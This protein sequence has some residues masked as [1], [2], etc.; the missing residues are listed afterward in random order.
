MKN[1]YKFLKG[2]VVLVCL[3]LPT[4]MSSQEKSVVNKLDSLYAR[5]TEQYDNRQL[6]EAVLSYIKI[7]EAIN[8]NPP[9]SSSIYLC[10]LYQFIGGIYYDLEDY[11]KALDFLNLALEKCDTL[12]ATNRADYPLILLDIALAHVGLESYEDA[13]DYMHLAIISDTGLL[14]ND[15]VNESLNFLIQKYVERG[16]SFAEA[17]DYEDALISITKASDVVY[18]LNMKDASIDLYRLQG[19]LYSTQKEYQ[20]AIDYYSKAHSLCEPNSA[21]HASILQ[22]IGD[23][24]ENLNNFTKALE[25]YEQ[26]LGV[27]RLVYGEEHVTY[28]QCLGVIGYLYARLGDYE[29]ALEC[30]FS[31]RS[32][33]E[34]VLGVNHSTYANCLDDIGNVYLR[35]GEIDAA[36]KSFLNALEIYNSIPEKES[37][38]YAKTLISIG[39]AY[40]IKGDYSKSIE[41]LLAA[42]EVKEK[43]NN[44]NDF[45]YDY[46][47][48][49]NN[50]GTSYALL[51]DYE[52]G[53]AFSLNSLEYCERLIGTNHPEYATLLIIISSYYLVLGEYGKALEYQLNAM[54]IQ[55]FVLGKEHPDYADTLDSIGMTYAYLNDDDKALDFFFK[56]LRIKEKTVGKTN[57]QYTTILHHIGNSYNSKHDYNN[58]LYYFNLAKEI[59]AN[60]LGVNHPRYV[61]NIAA[62]G[63]VYGNMGNNEKAKE[64]CFAALEARKNLLG[65]E[66]IDTAYA[67]ENIGSLYRNLVDYDSAIKC[68]LTA[69]SIYEKNFGKIHPDY[70]DCLIRIAKCYYSLGD[71]T[72]AADYFISFFD[73]ASSFV[74]HSFASLTETQRYHFWEQYNNPFTNELF[75]YATNIA[76]PE[77]SKMAYNA[78]LLGKGL[79]LNAE[80]EMRKLILESGDE[81]AIGVYNDIQANRFKLDKLYDQHSV[82][83][84]EIDSLS[85][86]IENLQRELIAR[87]KVYGDY[88]KNL[89]LEWEDVQESLGRHDI[90]I[91]F[92]TYTEK[93]TTFYIAITVRSDYSEPHIVK[94]FSSNDLIKIK[95]L[96]YYKTSI[97]NELIWG[98]LSNELNGIKNVFF[99][100]SGELCNISIENLLEE[101]GKHL[102]SDNRNYYR[103]TSTREVYNNRDPS[104]NLKHATIYGGIVYESPFY[105][106]LS[107]AESESQIIAICSSKSSSQI[108]SLSLSRGAWD[109]LPG[110]RKEAE[111]ISSTLSSHRI[112]NLLYEGCDGTEESFK[113]LDG[114]ENSVIHIATHGFYWTEKEAL[115]SFQNTPSFVLEN[116]TKVIK[117]DKAL[118]RSGLLFAGAKNTLDGKE[119]PIGSDDGI[120][121]A[122]EISRMDLRGTG[123]VVLSACQSGLGDITGDGVFGLQRGLKKA[124]VQT[125]VMSLWKVSD[126]AT[127]IMMTRFYKN[128]VKGKS[129]YASF[130]EAKEYLRKYK[131]GSFNNS[132]YYAAFVILDAI[133]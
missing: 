6:E 21:D 48:L 17:G 39:T 38:Y 46:A 78:A 5:A 13:L 125:I 129:K 3:S 10:P 11:D 31:A 45:D 33:Y 12:I 69:L 91:E 127:M 4:F 67:M 81:D 121:T 132:N 100:P 70:S 61:D 106:T 96:M 92:E 84:I 1:R 83:T 54:R 65:D 59:N 108:D 123:L 41:S 66:H 2:A 119:I 103:L 29:K 122:K 85:A 60:S 51:G 118:T 114:T 19:T 34:K 95:P 79:L 98:K 18:D 73:A 37:L 109:Y 89:S 50:L 97:L 43:T 58:A 74:T 101:D 22:D 30:L 57:P 20:K 82:N 36:L 116:D 110:T 9:D 55:E 8:Q 126:E 40:Q 26:A 15:Y 14:D 52:S 32:I 124:G 93:D 24:Y 105:S 117:E 90:A 53:L 104:Y 131:G 94:L 120:L 35:R 80:T 28:S 77:S 64:Y 130:Q 88:S 63:A 113:S 133:E 71:Y 128:L 87:S 16:T 47:R 27:C 42:K 102:V 62:I 72:S 99:S 115:R 75:Y 25:F 107:G 23:A 56:S 44:T 112:K 7:T 86:H 76:T 111:S 49:L 68:Y